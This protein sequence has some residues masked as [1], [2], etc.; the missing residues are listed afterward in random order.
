MAFFTENTTKTKDMYKQNAVIMGRK[1]WECIP[2]KYKPLKDRINIV[3]TSQNLDL[4]DEAIVCKSL[5]AALDIICQPKLQEKV[6]NI[7]II[8]GHSVYK[9][10]MES[11]YFYRLYL[12]KVKGIFE[13]D[14]FFPSIPH[15][16]EVV[17]DP[18]I[19]K[20]IQE[21]DGIEYEFKVYKKV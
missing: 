12:T 1:T 19:P 14:T 8:G 18:N 15:N 5:S 16:F 20:G 10:A 4:G 6:E 7:W 13:C 21:E 11:P 9:E 3:L 2:N 17:D